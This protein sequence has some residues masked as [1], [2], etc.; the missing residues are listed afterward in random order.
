[1]GHLSGLTGGSSP[2]GRASRGT[3]SDMKHTTKAGA[4]TIVIATMMT[5]GCSGG[6]SKGHESGSGGAGSDAAPAALAE[7]F[8]ELLAYDWTV[9]PGTETYFCSYKTLVEDLW[10][11]DIRPLAPSGTH[12]VVLSFADPGPPDGVYS[13]TDASAP[14]PCN[15]LPVGNMV[16]AGFVGTDD[17]IMP[18][19]V[20]V[21]IP[22]GKQLIL[23]LH[24]YNTSDSPLSDRSGVE[25]VKPDPSKVTNEAEVIFSGSVLTLAVP[26]GPSTTTA[27]CTMANDETIFAVL[28]HMHRTG[29]HMTTKA[30]HADG[31]T[32]VLLNQ[33]YEFTAQKYL[34][35]APAVALL[36][37]EKLEVACSYENPGTELHFGESTDAE[38]CFSLVYRYPAK[39]ASNGDLLPP[40]TCDNGASR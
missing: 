14:V 26:P 21:K 1:M 8:E 37:G 30:I 4:L 13:S 34:P 39:A 11:G 29:V 19:G 9:D 15:G 24:L 23:N 17:F 3:W 38:M 2:R 6:S 18:E 12:H 28:P 10:V 20:A 31:S 5:A 32:E 16:Y 35:V 33:P 40:L 27:D 7:H 36:H 22:A 25:V